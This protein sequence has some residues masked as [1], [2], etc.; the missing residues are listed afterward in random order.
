MTGTSGCS[1]RKPGDTAVC[2]THPTACE[3]F[4][5]VSSWRRLPRPVGQQPIQGISGSC[6]G[7]AGFSFQSLK[8]PRRATPLRIF[9]PQKPWTNVVAGFARIR[10]RTENS[11]ILANPATRIANGVGRRGMTLVELLVV[12][13]VIGLLIGLL[14]PAVNAAR[15][16]A[17]RTRCTNNM[18]QLGV[19][20]HNHHSALRAFPFGSHSDVDDSNGFDDDGFGWGFALL[21]YLEEASLHDRLAPYKQPGVFE[22]TFSNT[23]AIVPGG[24]TNLSVFRCPSSPLGRHVTGGDPH[25]NGYA[26]SDYR[27]SSGYQDRGLFWKLADGL[28]AGFN[29]VRFKNI[30]DGTSRT[31]ALGESAYYSEV[32]DWPIWLGAND[33]DESAMFKTQLPSIINCGIAPRVQDLPMAVDDDCAFSWHN[34]DGAHFVFADGSVHFLSETID[35]PVYQSLG[36][37]MDGGPVGDY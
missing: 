15:E 21:P 16:A 36:D 29:K 6:G 20:L 30:T 37:R 10:G 32:K 4:R 26:T 33:T 9:T 2:S 19:A 17:R 27:A 24:E 8:G 25:R 13:A 7:K 12:V 34:G 22:T 18:K 35:F 5:P 28:A 11:R 23:S 1:P 3:I 14:L 31:I